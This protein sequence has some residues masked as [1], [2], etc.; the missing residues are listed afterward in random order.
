MKF[1]AGILSARQLANASEDLAGGVENRPGQMGFCIGYIR[2]YPVWA[3]AKKI[4]FPSLNF[5]DCLHHILKWK[6]HFD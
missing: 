5:H 6:C 2:D 3:S 4:L 1:Q